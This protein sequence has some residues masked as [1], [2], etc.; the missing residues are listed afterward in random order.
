MLILQLFGA[1]VGPDR[2]PYEPPPLDFQPSR[3]AGLASRDLLLVLG[4]CAVL[5]LMLFLWAYLTRRDRLNRSS[6]GSPVIY[7]SHRDAE[8]AI[9]RHHH[10]RRRRRHEEEYPR[11]PT[12]KE[13]GGLPPPRPD[14]APGPTAPAP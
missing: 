3:L 2:S 13:T 14:D 4:A 11:N 5:G 9:R 10:R 12:L 1:V 6:N 7:R 8:H